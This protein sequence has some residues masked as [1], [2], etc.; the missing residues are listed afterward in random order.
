MSTPVVKK[1][2]AF[3]SITPIVGIFSDHAGEH[4]DQTTNICGVNGKRIQKARDYYDC[5]VKT[6]PNLTKVYILHRDQNTASTNS[7]NK[8]KGRG[9]LPVPISDPPLTLKTAP[10]TDPS[11][12]I[13]AL[14]GTV[15][16]GPT[17]GLLVLPVDVFFGAAN[18][19]FTQAKARLLSVAWPA[20]DWLPPAVCAHG[21]A[22]ELCGQLMGAQV[23]YILTNPKHIPHGA[24]RFVDVPEDD[25]KCVASQAAAKA[26]NI[27]LR[28]HRGLQII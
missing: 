19:I 10:G 16:P 22:Q 7:F 26:L 11:S 9:A 13:T 5:F 2:E 4:F 27:E 6:I 25:I 20:T 15:P 12:D 23:A 14:I 21:A 8:I 24:A 1:A 28:K 17:S 18:L 3:D